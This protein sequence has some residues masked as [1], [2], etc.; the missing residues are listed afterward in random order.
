MAIT[1]KTKSDITDVVLEL[2]DMESKMMLDA[3]L[4]PIEI[5]IQAPKQLDIKAVYIGRGNTHSSL[6]GRNRNKYWLPQ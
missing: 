2:L 5:T 1:D 6:K 4:E 3:L